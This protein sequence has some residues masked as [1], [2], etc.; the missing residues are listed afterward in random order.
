MGR[1]KNKETGFKRENWSVLMEKG[2]SQGLY[3]Y[4]TILLNWILGLKPPEHESAR[5]LWSAFL[6]ICSEAS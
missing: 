6:E 2:R 1:H 3:V 4:I 5:E